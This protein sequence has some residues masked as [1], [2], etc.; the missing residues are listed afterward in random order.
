M[1]DMHNNNGRA[2]G[3]V[4]HDII[5]GFVSY[6]IVTLSQQHDMLT[7]CQNALLSIEL[8]RIRSIK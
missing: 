8:D 4:G 3:N 6:D 5:A 1:Y 7:F 2:V